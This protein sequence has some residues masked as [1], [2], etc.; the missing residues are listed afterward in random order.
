MSL[1][2]ELAVRVGWLEHRREGRLPARELNATY[3]AGSKRK[4]VP[5]KDIS[6][7][8]LYL[9]T[10]DRWMPGAGIDLTLR[11]QSVFEDQP[12]ESVRLRARS[13]RLGA[14][15]VGLAFE[16]E[17][18]GADVWM[19][20][21]VKA[22]SA[23][24]QK[25]T[26]RALRIS[27]ALSFLRRVSPAAESAV[28]EHIAGE[29]IFESGERAVETI[30]N[31]E[32]LVESWNF[33][34]RTGVDPSL[35]LNILENASRTNSESI[36]QHWTG[37]LASSVQYWARDC[38][39]AKFIS[40]LSLLDPVQIRILQAVCSRSLRAGR[41]AGDSFSRNL[42]YSNQA[43]RIMA[44][45]SS[46][47]VIEQHLDC[48]SY[49]ELL[50]PAIKPAWFQEF[51][52][53]ELTPTRLGLKFYARCR[54]LLDPPDAS[55]RVHAKPVFH[56]HTVKDDSNFAHEESLRMYAPAS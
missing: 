27:R 45:I 20:L 19:S 44:G 25:D 35:I 5:V 51:E 55:A 1:V 46:F 43:M 2:R 29:S 49:L 32:E 30:L 47:Q 40:L 17:H 12:A 15:G 37:L 38:E 48:L 7:G 31:A 21:F 54:G 14:D 33:A 22:A 16:P 42:A 8:G 41:D 53:I 34:I 3:L 6:S 13:V 56:F 28:L 18:V 9:F 11:K 39:S 26:V 10:G 4:R 52:E 23:L 24:R 36:R 50:E